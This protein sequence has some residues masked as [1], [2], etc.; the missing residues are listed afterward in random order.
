MA[1]SKM[2]EALNKG[3]R[4]PCLKCLEPMNM[5]AQRCPHC[6]SD[7]SDDEVKTNV[8]S[9][10]AIPKGCLIVFGITPKTKA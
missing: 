9:K 6:K 4:I 7:F 10:K 1:E 8:A 2:T 3:M 5:A